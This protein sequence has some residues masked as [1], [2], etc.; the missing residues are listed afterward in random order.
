MVKKAK[1]NYQVW[2]FF[3]HLVAVV[4]YVGITRWLPIRFTK[5]FP[6]LWGNPEALKKYINIYGSIFGVL[7]NISSFVS[8]CRISWDQFFQI[9]HDEARNAIAEQYRK[10]NFHNYICDIVCSIIPIVLLF[11]LLVITLLNINPA[12]VTEDVKNSTTST[13]GLLSI[14]SDGKTLFIPFITFVIIY[15]KMKYSI[16]FSENDTDKKETRVFV[17]LSKTLD[18]DI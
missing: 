3:G 6:S 14:M 13:T 15:I 2:W 11:V 9:E 12:M 18:R 17:P 7:W 10:R 16:V 5:Q 4:C 1:N 8:C